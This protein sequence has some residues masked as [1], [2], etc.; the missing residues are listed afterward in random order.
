MNTGANIGGAISPSLTPWL[1]AEWGWPVALC[2]AAAI[3]ALGGL[4]WLKIDT[5]KALPD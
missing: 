1:A 4:M 2:T 3:A 5:S